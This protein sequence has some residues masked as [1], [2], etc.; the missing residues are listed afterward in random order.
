MGA[1]ETVNARICWCRIPVNAVIRECTV[2]GSLD[3]SFPLMSPIGKPSLRGVK[4]DHAGNQRIKVGTLT[5]GL[6]IHQAVSVHGQWHPYRRGEFASPTECPTTPKT[7]AHGFHEAFRVRLK[8]SEWGIPRKI[9]GGLVGISRQLDH[10]EEG[11]LSTTNLSFALECLQTIPVIL[12]ITTPS[13][14]I[15]S[16]RSKAVPNSVDNR[17]T[18]S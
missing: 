7:T 12:S 10:H 8:K 13:M 5:P 1:A 18:S 15:A 16:T 3:Q 17:P 6:T 2:I 11:A 14:T 9:V 4:V